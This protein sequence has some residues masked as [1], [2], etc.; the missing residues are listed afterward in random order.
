MQG[1]SFCPHRRVEAVNCDVLHSLSAQ[2]MD[3]VHLDSPNI[4]LHL[5][6]HLIFL[7]DWY[8]WVNS[9]CICGSSHQIIS[10][11]WA[12]TYLG[13]C[14]WFQASLSPTS[15]VAC[16]L[17]GVSSTAEVWVDPV[18]A[19]WWQSRKWAR[20]E[21]GICAGIK[22]LKRL[23]TIVP[24]LFT[25][26]E[27]PAD[28]RRVLLGSDWVLQVLDHSADVLQG[29]EYCCTMVQKR[30]VQALEKWWENTTKILS[31]IEF[32]F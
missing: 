20:T 9:Q 26:V 31:N 15:E 30:Q 25:V 12:L 28:A 13:H 22:Q 2:K 21:T 4:Y 10:K 19:C 24:L 5:K 23:I 14:D 18:S 7:G 16:H 1:G 17:N 11:P 8:R 32:Y 6:K 29:L 3:E 27:V